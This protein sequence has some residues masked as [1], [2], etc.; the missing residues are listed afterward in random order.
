MIPNELI[1]KKASR[2]ICD[3]AFIM[4]Y[5]SGLMAKTFSRAPVTNYCASNF[6]YLSKKSMMR[7]FTC[8]LLVV[9]CHMN[10]QQPFTNVDVKNL[11]EDKISIRALQ[12][13]SG[14][15]W[16]GSNEGIIGYFD[17][18]ENFKFEKQIDFNGNKPDFRSISSNEDHVLALNAGSP[19]L[20]YRI[21]K[22]GTG[23]KSVYREMHPDI[24]YDGLKMNGQ[25]G[26]A[27]GDPIDGCFSIIVSTDGGNSWIK[28]SCSDEIRAHEVEAAFAA[29][30]S[31][32]I[33]KENKVWFFTGGN[34]SRMFFSNDLGT[35]WTNS[36]LPIVQGNK[37]TGIFCA[38]FYDVN[39]GIAA[40]GDYDQ[41]T[42]NK[43]NKA[44]TTDGGRT[45]NLVADGAGFGYASAI[46][47]VPGSNA[48]EIVSVGATGLWYSSD[49]GNS[50]QKLLDDSNLYTIEFENRNTAYAA[51]KGKL[52][53]L[54]FK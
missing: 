15:I 14:K 5:F 20:L 9:G 4:Y 2:K 49:R 21:R 24:F 51:G 3:F 40:G 18:K 13:D 16:F 32:L 39:I 10:S 28:K 34:H 17:Q 31:T 41:P 33:V 6:F 30:N 36:I 43:S 37:M 54:D 47:F 7:I 53:R 29:S 45:W 52:V 35:S 12:F 8:I 26:I 22:D 27:M 46:K 23:I 44:M 38:D 19:A 1:R 48:M 11:I 42:S 50:W 25:F